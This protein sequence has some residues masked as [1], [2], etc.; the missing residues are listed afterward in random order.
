[1]IGDA[2]DPNLEAVLRAA[3]D[4]TT[5]AFIDQRLIVGTRLHHPMQQLMDALSNYPPHWDV[6]KQMNAED[7][8][9]AL[10]EQS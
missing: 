8:R 5:E 1:M 10:E 4:V 6:L 2:L 7:S 9:A 3:I